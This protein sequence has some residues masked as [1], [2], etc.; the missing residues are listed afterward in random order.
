MSDPV[1]ISYLRSATATDAVAL[2]AALAQTD[3]PAFLDTRA[4]HVGEQFPDA[5]VQ[6]ILNARVF[7]LFASADYFDSPYCWREMRLALAEFDAKVTAGATD[8]EK[9]A[10]LNHLVVALPL[11]GMP[12]E[13]MTRLPAFLRTENWAPSSATAAIVDL[14]RS[15]A[16]A[17]TIRERHR[18]AGIS[19]QLQRALVTESLLPP[20]AN[21]SGLRIYPPVLPRSLGDGFVGRHDELWQIDALLSVR[22][23]ATRRTA[24]PVVALHGSAG[25]GKSRIALEYVYRFGSARFPGGI[26][27]VDASGARE[28][29]DQHYGILQ[30]LDP[31]GHT[32]SRAQLQAQGVNV[33]ERLARSLHLRSPDS[34]VLFVLDNVPEAGRGKPP[35]PLQTWCPA[36]PGEVAILATS[37]RRLNLG[38]PGIDVVTL[39][40]LTPDAAMGLLARD[41]D[42]SAAGP[43]TW[44]R[45]AESVGYFP[46]ALDLLNKCMIAQLTDVEELAQVLGTSRVDSV[47]DEHAGLLKEFVAEDVVRG[48]GDAFRTSFDLLPDDAKDVAAFMA[49]LAP[50]PIPLAFLEVIESNEANV[51]A[52][53]QSARLQ[54]SAFLSNPAGATP[55]GSVP[56]VGQMH[57]VLASYIR[58][59]YADSTDKALLALRVMALALGPRSGYDPAN[60]PLWDA[61]LPHVREALEAMGDSGGS[62]SALREGIRVRRLVATL[63]DPRGRLVEWASAQL[64]LA[65]ALNRLG[66]RSTGPTMHDEAEALCHG[67]IQRS[68][69][70]PAD[71]VLWAQG[72]LAS[73]LGDLGRAE[74]AVVLRR[75]IIGATDR[76]LEPSEWGAAQH[77]LA[78][79]LLRLADG[80]SLDEAILAYRAALGARDRE[81]V[82]VDWAQT[83]SALGLAL[84]Q[85]A[86]ADESE[87]GLENLR[88]AVSCQRAA[89]DVLAK[90]RRPR[91]RAVAQSSLGDAL[92]EL[93]QRTNDPAPRTEAIDAYFEALDA[94]DRSGDP[95]MWG[96]LQQTIGDVCRLV[97]SSDDASDENV[98]M[99]Q[100]ALDCFDAA[101]EVF[102]REVDEDRWAHLQLASGELL[103][104][105]ARLRPERPE[106]EYRER[107][108]A[109]LT[110]VLDALH[111]DDPERATAVEMLA[112]TRG[113]PPTDVP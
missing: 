42:Y 45:I 19:P 46:L 29:A 109:A 96:G 75:A 57:R 105:M 50:S 76:T 7:V 95:V 5:L 43:S 71:V 28:V 73:T 102:T 25:T 108:I 66:S 37:I 4:I 64:H 62:S 65:A 38:A 60:W 6:A 17:E 21:L 89:L 40:M 100:L 59:R 98:E 2:H 48:V 103:W 47:L 3:T 101:R 11:G 67:V 99:I 55:P 82:R 72:E 1:F 85:R 61:S 113:N 56:V 68:D 23:G 107:A 86:Q 30:Q 93:G 54:S 97:A 49:F 70:L 22:N 36:Q 88:E 26:F 8:G 15:R 9:R 92:N 111:A 112:Q 10:A 51:P 39:G 41:L 104:S 106:G 84:Y 90:D 16:S 13:R 58:S 94:T 35:L 79:E 33:T 27:W 24:A 20:A 18:A 83:Q 87:A 91:D 77:N 80:D 34:L 32:A 81:D 63:F 44:S 53:V 12:A 74:E 110:D 78:N 52:R 69:G 31:E 14:V